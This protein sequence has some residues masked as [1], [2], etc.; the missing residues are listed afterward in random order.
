MVI[1]VKKVPEGVEFKESLAEDFFNDEVH[2]SDKLPALYEQLMNK[3]EGRAGNNFKLNPVRYE[4]IIRYIQAG[5]YISHAANAVGISEDTIKKWIRN[6]VE[7]SDSIYGAF[8][9]DLKRAKATAIMRNVMIV[10]RAAQDDWT[11]A[12][13][14]LSVMEPDIFGNK[15]TVRTEITAVDTKPDERRIIISNEELTKLAMI[16]AHIEEQNKVVDADYV[17][18]EDEDETEVEYSAEE[19]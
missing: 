4:T 6:G 9:D 1:E 13:W 18:I 3:K 8:V 2:I 14:L 19:K 5:A 7:D 10:Q 16:Q 17:T 11:A 15:S 12:K